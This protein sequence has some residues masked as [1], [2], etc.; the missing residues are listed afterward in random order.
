MLGDHVQADRRLVEKEDLGTVEQG[1]DELHLHPLAE[2]KFANRPAQQAMDV[3]HLGQ[4][5]AG[6]LE[7]LRIDVINML[8]QPER[9]GGRQVPPE[10]VLLAH[11]Q[12]ETA[13]IGVFAFPGHVA[14]HRSRA[15]GGGE[16]AGE[17]FQ[18]GRLARPVGP[19]KGDEFARFDRQIDAAD[20]LDGL[21]IAMKKPANGSP[22]SLFFLKNAVR[23]RQLG[24]FDDWHG[25]TL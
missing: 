2:R 3:E 15:T 20:G 7:L 12:G 10:L 24:D 1:G 21:D 8:M 6:L 11:H 19:E 9:L 16:H 23:F 5:I 14:D 22:E 4:A 13:A 17:Q 25:E 18:R